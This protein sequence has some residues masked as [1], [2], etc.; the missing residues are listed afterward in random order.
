MTQDYLVARNSGY[1]FGHRKGRFF[2]AT[3][4]EQCLARWDGVWIIIVLLLEASVC[5]GIAESFFAEPFEVLGVVVRGVDRVDF[6]GLTETLPSPA[7]TP[8][9]FDGFIELLYPAS[10]LVGLNALKGIPSTADVIF[11]DFLGVFVEELA[12][13]YVCDVSW[14]FSLS[15]SEADKANALEFDVV[16][17]LPSV[18]K[19]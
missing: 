9:D 17:S 7:A 18:F 5:C 1:G 2:R 11:A 14:K 8:V 13:L 10:A 6:D 3:L 15:L 4:E 19:D 16:G 12:I